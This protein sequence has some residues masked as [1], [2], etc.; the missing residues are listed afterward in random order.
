MVMGT[1]IVSVAMELKGLHALSMVMLAFA[2]AGYLVITALT[3]TRVVRHRA[4]VREDFTDP[5][6]GFGFLTFT[7][8]SGVLGTRLSEVWPPAAW[9]LLALTVASG[10]VLGYIVPWTAVLHPSLRPALPG[11]NG[12][13]FLLVVAAQSVA[14]LSAVL[15]PESGPLHHELALLAVFCW[16]VGVLLYAGVAILVAARL[17][18]YPLR[19]ADMVPAY[20]IAMGATAITVLAG[21]RIVEMSDAPMVTATRGLITGSTVVIWCFGAWMIP[22]LIAAGL[23]RHAIHR[24]PLRYDPTLWSIVFPVGMFGVSAHYLGEVDSL[25][26][27]HGLGNAWAW[28]GLVVWATVFAAMCVHLVRTIALAPPQRS[29]TAP[30]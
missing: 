26:V 13:W 30:W 19:A 17:L 20:W 18:L 14:V 8:A 21:A 25:P 28:V 15:Q 3:V 10:A 9:T 5:R 4:A 22:I 16:S 6:R 1:G 7:A 12:T 23:W 11:T 27:V 29:A 2:V 24:Y